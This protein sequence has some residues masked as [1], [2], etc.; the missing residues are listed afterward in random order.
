MKVDT[1]KD[2]EALIKMCNK[3]GVSDIS[4]D[5]IVLKLSGEPVTQKAKNGNTQAD[6]K[7]DAPDEFTPEQILMWSSS[8][9]NDI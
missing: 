3:Q 1:L 2:L 8:V 6:D 7:V 4:V 5:G 9:A